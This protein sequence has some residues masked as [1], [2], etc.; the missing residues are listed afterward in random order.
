MATGCYTPRYL[1]ASFKGVSFLCT[2]AGSEHGRRGAEGEFP[3]GENTAYGDLGRRIRHYSLKGVFREN[4]HIRDA[5]GLIAAC[6][7]P[8]PGPL[9][10][11]TRGTVQAACK[12]IKVRD[13]IEDGMGETHVELEFIEAN[14]WFG[15]FNFG[16]SLAGIDLT[17]ITSVVQTFFNAN[18]NPTTALVQSKPAIRAIAS[19]AVGQI[20]TSLNRAAGIN[21]NQKYWRVSSELK[22]I[23]G[24]D[25]DLGN[26]TQVWNAIAGGMSAIDTFATSSEVKMDAFRQVANW[27]VGKGT[28]LLSGAQSVDAILTTVRVLAGARMAKAAFEVSAQTLQDAFKQYDMVLKILDG[29]MK[30][31]RAACNDELSLELRSFLASAQSVLLNR[32]YNLPAVVQYDFHGPVS[33]LVAA[34]EIYGNAKRFADVEKYNRS[35]LPHTLGPLVTAVSK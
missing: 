18:F 22:S 24:N 27:V 35:Q 20:S 4:S 11:P 1:T 15:G 10:H 3:F 33:S 26:K 7:S 12:S 19:G 28:P 14:D 32:A 5:G 17:S 29:E 34:W 31:A 25:L 21:T 16:A 8:G 2:E 13:E 23:A 9:V 30:L 6:E